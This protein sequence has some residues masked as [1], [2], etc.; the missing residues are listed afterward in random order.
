MTK[1]IVIGLVIGILVGG[2]SVWLLQKPQVSDIETEAPVSRGFG[3]GFREG[4]GSGSRSEI[5]ARNCLADEC[6]GIDEVE[7][8]VGQLEEEAREALDEA[9]QD[10]FKARG[11]YA[12]VIERFGMVR[13]FAMIIRAEDQHI[14]ALKAIYDRYGLEVPEAAPLD[15]EVSDSLAEMCEVGVEA[16]IANAALYRDR[17]LPKVHDH[18]D[19]VFVFTN[20]MLASEERHLP[21][22]RR[23]AGR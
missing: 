15:M 8:P 6:L 11:T 1:R 22:F 14:N 3:L 19:I 21:A 7:Y 17:L 10:E 9:I 18:E 13:P 2:A 23:C 4:A 16:E 5:N 12:L 20:L